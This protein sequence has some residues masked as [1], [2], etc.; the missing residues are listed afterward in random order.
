MNERKLIVGEQELSRERIVA[1]FAEVEGDAPTGS[2]RRCARHA[3]IIGVRS[4]PVSIQG[5][6]AAP[7]CDDTRAASDFAAAM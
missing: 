7:R 6:I 3:L 2:R 1:D 5:P 4:L